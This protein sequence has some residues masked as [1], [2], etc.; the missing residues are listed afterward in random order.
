MTMFGRLYKYIADPGI[1]ESVL[2]G[3]VKFTPIK[4]LNDPSELSPTMNPTEVRASLSRLRRD[5]Y[6]EQDMIHL[7]RQGHVLRRLAPRFQA[8]GVPRT[9]E[10]ATALIR[11]PFYDDLPRLERLLDETA[12]EI[13]SKVGLFC[14]SLRYDSLPMWA[15]YAANA[16]G[17]LLEFHD[18]DQAFTGDE[19]G[20][21]RQ[22]VAVQYERGRTGITFEP[23][24][25]EALFYSKFADWS[26]EQEVRVVIPLGEC[27]Q[28]SAGG[29]ILFLHDLSINRVGRIILGWNMLPQKSQRVREIAQAETGVAIVQARFERG[30]VTI[31]GQ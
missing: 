25:H 13:S 20:V 11:S 23:K 6:S 10:E 21:L 7:R 1:V 29:R 27:R 19:T 26:Y 12:R 15:H 30:R 24:S 28:V 2:K 9:R 18:L 4:E 17:L 22:P 3:A 14:L 5:G 31:D 8:V 16:G